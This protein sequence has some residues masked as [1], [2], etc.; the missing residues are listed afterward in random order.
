MT[1]GRTQMGRR[2]RSLTSGFPGVTAAP[3]DLAAAPL[4]DWA[5]W[6]GGPLDPPA[7]EAVLGLLALSG[8]R[9][10][11]LACPNQ[12]PELVEELMLTL[13]RCM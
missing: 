5:G 7:A 13:L 3:L 1:S 10:V 2:T 12:S 9:A 6:R 8:G 4:L 11:E